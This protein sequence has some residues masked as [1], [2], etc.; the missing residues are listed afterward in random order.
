MKF[1]AAFLFEWGVRAKLNF[2][3]TDAK[4]SFALTPHSM[5]K[6]K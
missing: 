2:A 5:I 3:V 1:D 4:F 6:M